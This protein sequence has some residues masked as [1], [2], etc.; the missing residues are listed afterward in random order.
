MKELPITAPPRAVTCCA[1][2][3]KAI[4]SFKV[5]L[6]SEAVEPTRLIA[7]AKSP[8]LTAKF[9]SALV[10]LSTKSALV[11]SSLLKLFKAAV[12]AVAESEKSIPAILA[13]IKESLVLFKVSSTPKPCLANSKADLEASLKLTE[14]ELAAAKS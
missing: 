9:A 10:S 13:K 4:V 5:T 8:A 3:T 14:T 7:S 11:M 1:A 12:I 6:A 2:V